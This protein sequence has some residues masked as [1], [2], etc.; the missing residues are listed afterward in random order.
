M[1][2]FDHNKNLFL[3]LA[4]LAVIIGLCAQ[5]AFAQK[6]AKIF[7]VKGKDI[8]SY[9]QAIDGFKQ[10][11]L[12]EWSITEYDLGGTTKNTPEM[13]R[14]IND[15]KPDIVLAVG[16]KSLAAVSQAK[17]SQPVVFCMAMK[18]S[19]YDLQGINATGISLTVSPEEQFN[20]L[21]SFTPKVKRLGILLWKKAPPELLDS[22]K[23]LAE[24]Q[25]VEIVPIELEA[26]NEIPQKLRAN[27]N[28]IDALWML[29]DAYIHSK[30]TLDFVVQLTLKNN[31]PF[32]A[33]SEVFVKEGAL[34]SLSPSYFDNGKQTAKLVKKILEQNINPKDIP[35]SY[36]EKP[37]L[38]INMETARKLNV[39]IPLEVMDRASRF[40]K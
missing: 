39:H 14:K 3:R 11:A 1:R 31:M 12:P 32:M 5:P 29:D 15:A 17:I 20:I 34:A 21:T 26:E 22:I 25:K 9:N 33:I 23:T 28:K 27:I 36:H 7:V 19:A 30:E 10:Q 16:A 38:V 37:D 24:T 6:P 18:P 2:L 4:A 35:I 13:L 8:L 40:I